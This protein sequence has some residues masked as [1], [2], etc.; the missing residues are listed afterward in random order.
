M[1]EE[2]KT[3]KSLGVYRGHEGTV[4]AID[5][6]YKY[7]GPHNKPN[8]SRGA[9]VAPLD[10][11]T[12]AVILVT[13][14][15]DQ[16][17]MIWEVSTNTHT[18]P[19]TVKVEQSKRLKGHSGDVYAIEIAQDDTLLRFGNMVSGGDYTIKTWNT[20]V[21]FNLIEYRR[22]RVIKHYR[23]IQDTCPVSN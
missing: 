7:Q 11:D 20:E 3:R 15:H 4:Y 2:I 1:A 21:H 9:K 10:I 14:S 16:S 8:P 12:D 22:E 13:G 18:R 6:F 5:A 19:E 17:I 23:A